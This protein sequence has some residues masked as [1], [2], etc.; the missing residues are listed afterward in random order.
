VTER[1]LRHRPGEEPSFQYAF[2][3]ASATMFGDIAETENAPFRVTI[4]EPDDVRAGHLNFALADC[5]AK[6]IFCTRGGYGSARLLRHLDSRMTPV[7]KFLVGHSDVTSLHL[8]ISRIWPQVISVH[9]PHIATRHLL[10]DGVE[11]ELNRRSL[12]DSL[13]VDDRVLVEPVEFL[14]HG[15]ARGPLLG[16]CL[17]LVASAIG[18]DF[19]PCP[20]GTI[21]FLEDTGEPPYR[22]DRMLTQLMHAGAFDQ[23]RGVIFGAMRRC[24]DPYNDLKSVLLDLFYRFSFPIAFGLKSGHGDI[25][26][27]ARL[28]APIELDSD[29]G[30]VRIGKA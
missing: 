4:A 24:T 10:G 23:V 5:Q 3:H 11:C 25:N 20:S 22:I 12:H 19:A 27:S 13:F 14:R 16:G 1:A 9:G 17:S 26:L 2:E 30:V 18:T 15:R 6:A 29:A 21:L 7:P 8:A 28:G